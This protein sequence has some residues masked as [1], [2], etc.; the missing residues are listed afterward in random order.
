MVTRGIFY[1]KLQQLG[2][3]TIRSFLKLDPNGVP[4]AIG[5]KF[6]ESALSGLSYDTSMDMMNMTSIHV[7]LPAEAKKTVFDHLEVNW[8][9]AG[10]EPKAISVFPILIFIFI[11]SLRLNRHP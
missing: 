7:D 10:H 3:G 1:G 5:L 6:G 4:Q 11:W 8:N 2:K 9:P